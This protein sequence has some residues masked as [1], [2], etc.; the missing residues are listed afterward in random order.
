MTGPTLWTAAPL[1]LGLLGLG[2]FAAGLRQMIRGRV[3]VSL[4]TLLGGAIL[5]CLG[6]G[7]GTVGANLLTYSRLTYERP[8]AEVS[9][10]GLD[11]RSKEY[12]VTVRPVDSPPTTCILQGDEW[13]L[14]AKVQTWQPW[15]NVLGFDATYTLDQIANKY[16]DA[17]EANGKPITA[18]DLARREPPLTRYMPVRFTVWATSILQLQNRR[19]GSANYMPLANGADYRVLITEQGLVA[20]PINEFA[21]AAV[22]AQTP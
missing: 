15:A 19:F 22:A 5:A 10:V 20:E 6:V 21:R 2:F 8:V 14:S 18:C 3:L 13:L 1:I 12:S 9:V 17:A 16:M 11:A 7:L 4:V